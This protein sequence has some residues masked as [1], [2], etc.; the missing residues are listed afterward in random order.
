M[1]LAASAFAAGEPFAKGDMAVGL[2]DAP[3]TVVEYASMT[4]PHCANFHN[5]TYKD[6]KAKYVDTGKVR[7][8]FREF[9]LD[10]LALRASMLARCAGPAKFFG[11]LDILFKQQ[12][13]WARASD[14]GKALQQL[15]RMGGISSGRFKACMENEELI[16]MI[17]S[18]RLEGSKKFG[19]NSTPSFI[20]NGN[21]HSAMSMEEWDELLVEYLN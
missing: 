19:V 17:L 13:K 8:I 12:S 10:P 5:S 7:L 2:E 6:F 15:A 11:M 14:P 18:T 21:K 1:L 20:V 3:V 16:N 4:C 9:P